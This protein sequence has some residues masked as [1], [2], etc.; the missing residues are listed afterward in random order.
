MS[1][2]GRLSL[3]RFVD[4]TSAGPNRI[5]GIANKGRIALGY[6]ADFTVVDLKARR[7]ITNGWMET[8]CGWTPFDGMAV[9]GWPRATVVRGNIVMRDDELL[10]LPAG[11]PVAFQECLPAA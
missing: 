4:L 6:D 10:G 3:E 11:A 7:T 8:R 5:Y 2:A 9:T 1:I